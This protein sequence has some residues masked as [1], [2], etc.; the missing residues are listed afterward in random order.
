MGIVL[1]QTDKAT[2]PPAAGDRRHC[3]SATGTENTLP[4]PLEDLP[5]QSAE[6]QKPV[7]KPLSDGIERFRHK[8]GGK[9]L[10]P[11]D[12]HYA[13]RPTLPE[14]ETYRFSIGLEPIGHFA[15]RKF[16]P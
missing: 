9:R 8:P 4:V 3:A 2:L 15:F 1:V 12:R 6:G 5:G 16:Q 14:A 7:V 11:A 10:L 13:D